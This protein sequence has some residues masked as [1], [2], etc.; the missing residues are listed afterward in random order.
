M[1]VPDM[2]ERRNAVAWIL[3]LTLVSFSG[4]Y[5]LAGGDGT[6][7]G[8]PLTGT[9]TIKISE[10]LSNPDDYLSQV[11]RVEGLVTDVCKKRGCWMS[12]ASE[13]EDFQ[14]IRIKV[15]DGVIVFPLES[16]GSHAIAEGVFHKIEMTLEQTLK[17]R[18]HQAQEHGEEFDP[19]TVTEPL[20][21]YQIKG[22]GAVIH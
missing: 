15:D 20:V 4:P 8:E 9:D 21:Y 13:D 14:E 18:E 11:V 6:S 5:A 22:R 10:L 3:C 1:E 16:K 7:Y 12:I 2:Q 19:S 17:Y